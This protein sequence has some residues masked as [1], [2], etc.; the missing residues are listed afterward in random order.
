MTSAA[1][2]AAAQMIQAGIAPVHT[3]SIFETVDD[4]ILKAYWYEALGRAK[5]TVPP[6]G[7]TVWLAKARAWFY[8]RRQ[9]DR[10]RNDCD[11]ATAAICRDQ[12]GRERDAHNATRQELESLK[13]KVESLER[14]APAK[15]QKVVVDNAVIRPTRLVS[16]AVDGL[17]DLALPVPDTEMTTDEKKSQEPPVP[18]IRLYRAPDD[19]LS[20]LPRSPSAV[21]VPR[22]VPSKKPD[23]QKTKTKPAEII[24]F[25]TI[26]EVLKRCVDWARKEDPRVHVP[27]GMIFPAPAHH[28]LAYADMIKEETTRTRF[29]QFVHSVRDGPNDI[30]IERAI[31]QLN[32]V[33]LITI[34]TNADGVQ[35]IVPNNNNKALEAVPPP[36]VVPM[37][38]QAAP[39]T[40]V[41][42]P[43]PSD[44]VDAVAQTNA[45]P[46]PTQ[47]SKDDDEICQRLREAVY[48]K[49]GNDPDGLSI[50]RYI[51][52]YHSMLDREVSVSEFDR[53]VARARGNGKRMI[54]EVRKVMSAN[55]QLPTQQRG[56]Y[57]FIL[58][59]SSKFADV[60]EN[61]DKKHVEASSPPPPRPV[62]PPV[63][64]VADPVLVQRIMPIVAAAPP[65]PASPVLAP[66]QFGDSA[67]EHIA[68]APEPKQPKS[69]LEVC[70][71]LASVC[72]CFSLRTVSRCWRLSLLD[73]KTS[74]K[75]NRSNEAETTMIK[76]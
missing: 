7:D 18:P 42:A 11:K 23:E 46:E 33:G 17:T 34:K 59:S 8:V 10:D 6:Y 20:V 51:M 44:V 52:I 75:R 73:H 61:M 21:V 4:Q 48:T 68:I 2:A 29:V 31:D 74:R 71:L 12:L 69:P 57:A 15:K 76:S 43:A 14:K 32:K 50:E 41:Q 54:C 47:S 40:V 60:N 26:Q 67:I 35:V 55:G 30:A 19:S 3:P 27:V 56:Q 58:P 39:V 49:A 70:R 16:A 65:P 5:E 36:P 25:D 64:P 66:V 63:T 37:E 72:H 24:S 62:L 38:E 9:E 53:I 1:A 28:V 13:R 22:P 45:V